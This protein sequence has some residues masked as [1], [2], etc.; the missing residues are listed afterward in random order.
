M[1]PQDVH[2]HVQLW[3]CCVL[4]EAGMTLSF[5]AFAWH[6]GALQAMMVTFNASV[7]ELRKIQLQLAVDLKATE[8]RL[9]LMLRELSLLKVRLTCYIKTAV[10][11]VFMLCCFTLPTPVHFEIN[12]SSCHSRNNTNCSQAKRR[13]SA[14]TWPFQLHFIVVHAYGM[15]QVNRKDH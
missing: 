14:A 5:C 3:L 15:C 1:W 9:L 6:S 4:L 2:T 12:V 8:G 10:C 13:P 7:S 11:K